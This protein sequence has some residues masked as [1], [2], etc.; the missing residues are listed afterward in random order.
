LLLL[1]LFI[2]DYGIVIVAAT[3]GS[4]MFTPVSITASDVAITV[5]TFAV[6]F[7]V[8]DNVLAA[9]G[10]DVIV[11]AAIGIKMLL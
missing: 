9:A 5:N 2:K 10:P 4:V 8:S 1:L 11:A 6:A 3:T 7:A